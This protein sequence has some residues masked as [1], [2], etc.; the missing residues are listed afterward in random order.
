[1]S[2]PTPASDELKSFFDQRAFVE[3][4]VAQINKDLLGLYYGD[5]SLSDSSQKNLLEELVTSLAPVLIELS[6]RQPEQLSQFIYRV[7]LGET[8]F[9]DALTADASFK[10]LAFLIIEREAMKVYLR[11]KFS[12]RF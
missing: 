11:I 6:K 2:L 8:K 12:E 1:M 3:S 10:K 4:T 9:F 5:F 7:D